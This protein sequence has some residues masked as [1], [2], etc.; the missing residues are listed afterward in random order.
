[1][2]LAFRKRFLSSPPLSL[3]SFYPFPLPRQSKIKVC[4]G[5]EMTGEGGGAGKREKFYSF[6]SAEALHC[7]WLL[8][9]VS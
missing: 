3:S 6:I 1:M 9:C 4:G 7:N 5:T 2:L 8:N